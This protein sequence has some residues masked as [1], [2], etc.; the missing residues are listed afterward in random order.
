MFQTTRKSCS[1]YFEKS[2]FASFEI[3]ICVILQLAAKK[4]WPLIPRK[5]IAGLILLCVNNSAATVFFYTGSSLLPLSTMQCIATS[6]IVISGIILYFIFL[7]EKPNVLMFVSALVCTC[8]IVL[9]V[10]PEFLFRY[11]LVANLSESIYCKI[12]LSHK[13]T[14]LFC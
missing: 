9:V 6:V 13:E 7:K 4:R 11:V 3:Q 14:T 1:F 8:G 10:Q 12:I 5:E 2:C